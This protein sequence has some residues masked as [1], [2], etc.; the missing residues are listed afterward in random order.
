MLRHHKWF[1]WLIL[2]SALQLTLAGCG[3]SDGS[4]PSSPTNLPY[5]SGDGFAEMV[6]VPTLPGTLA[7]TDTSVTVTVK[8]DDSTAAV[9]GYLGFISPTT[10]IFLS[11]AGGLSAPLIP[12]MATVGASLTFDNSKGSLSSVGSAYAVEII[13]CAVGV[14]CDLASTTAATN[15]FWYKIDP[16][17][18]NYIKWDL[19]NG[20]SPVNTGVPYPTVILE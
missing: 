3:N 20:T 6:Q 1:Y 17:S 13:T 4:S 8:V 9:A 5:S 12:G 14:T 11:E 15:S 7:T 18:G 10:G 2:G 16:A 19:P